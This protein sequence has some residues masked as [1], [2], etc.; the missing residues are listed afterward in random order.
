[1]SI[2]F[3]QCNLGGRLTRDPEV[4]FLAGDRSVTSFGLAINHRYKT[5]DGESKDDTTFVDVVAWG[6]TGELVAQYLKKGSG[7]L[8]T[9]RLKLDQWE[10]KDGQK[11]SKLTVVAESVQFTD[12]KPATDQPTPAPRSTTPTSGGA[13]TDEVPF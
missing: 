5:K 4:K 10:D 6:K 11:R 1:M 2:N 9:G 3:N 7:C 13:S 8:L 12:S